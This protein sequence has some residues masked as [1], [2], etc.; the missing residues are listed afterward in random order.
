MKLTGINLEVVI[1]LSKF[2]PGK[3]FILFA[4]LSVYSEGNLVRAERFDSF[5]R[6]SY[7]DLC[8]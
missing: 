6:S 3:Y 5:D 8:P 4:D 1:K 7:L 2:G